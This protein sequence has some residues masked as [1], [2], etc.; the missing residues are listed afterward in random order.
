MRAPLPQGHLI[1]RPDSSEKLEKEAQVFGSAPSRRVM[2]LQFI[3]VD[4]TVSY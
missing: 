2:Y 4:P 1:Q 3:Q